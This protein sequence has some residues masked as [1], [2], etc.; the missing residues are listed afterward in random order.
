M[1]QASPISGILIIVGAYAVAVAT[2]LIGGAP[3]ISAVYL[4]GTYALT[5]LA[6]FL[7]ARGILELLVG[8]DRDIAF[9]V[10]L[11]K[12]TDPL[13]AVISPVT[14]GFLMPFAVSL[15]GAFLFFF[16]KLFLFGDAYLDVPPLFIVIY[17][18]IV[19]AL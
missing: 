7:F 1:T 9:F 11:R 2:F 5:A 14:P 8:I 4:G 19:T 18:A 12:I 10:V 15:F 3:G 6:S 16:L 17:V 13:I